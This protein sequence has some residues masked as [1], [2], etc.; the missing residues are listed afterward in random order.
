MQK[1]SSPAPPK[2]KNRD[3]NRGF[4][5]SACTELNFIG[6]SRTVVESAQNSAD[7]LL[8]STKKKKSLYPCRDL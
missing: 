5:N 4:R 2:R 1:E 8:C 6:D 3:K 7:S